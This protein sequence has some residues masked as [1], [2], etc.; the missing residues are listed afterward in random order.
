ML[1]FIYVLSRSLLFSLSLDIS[2][3]LDMSLSICLDLSSPISPPSPLD[4]HSSQRCVSL[5][6]VSRRSWAGGYYMEA[7]SGLPVHRPREVMDR[8]ADSL[9][10]GLFLLSFQRAS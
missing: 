7:F 2:L 10:S 6:Q 1:A 8:N 4:L 9:L 5:M 3:S